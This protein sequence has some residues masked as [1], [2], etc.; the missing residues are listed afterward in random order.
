MIGTTLVA[1]TT[2]E[3]LVAAAFILAVA[4]VVLLIIWQLFALARRGMDQ[5]ADPSRRHD[6]SDRDQN[7]HQRGDTS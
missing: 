7:A 4:A 3:A 1:M 2:A 6:P 5:R